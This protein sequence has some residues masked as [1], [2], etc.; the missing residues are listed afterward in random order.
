MVGVYEKEMLERRGFKAKDGTTTKVLQ[1]FRQKLKRL[2]AV[3]KE[4]F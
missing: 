3:S 4:Y 2:T 1:W